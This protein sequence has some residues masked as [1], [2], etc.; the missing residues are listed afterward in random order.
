MSQE[1]CLLIEEKQVNLC[2]NMDNANGLDSLVSGF[3]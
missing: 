3:K 2:K 1:N